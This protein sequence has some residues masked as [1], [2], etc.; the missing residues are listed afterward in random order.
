MNTTIDQNNPVSTN[1]AIKI[2]KAIIKTQIAHPET[3]RKFG[4]ILLKGAPGVGKALEPIAN[5][6]S[7]GQGGRLLRM[8]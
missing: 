7:R 6:S 8:T 5:G 3:A 4:A 2:I 1:D